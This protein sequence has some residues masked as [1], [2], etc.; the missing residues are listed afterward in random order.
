MQNFQNNSSGEFF[1]LIDQ[2]VPERPKPKVDI[3]N[4]YGGLV[5]LDLKKTN[6]GQQASGNNQRPPY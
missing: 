6:N 4:E 5:D 3:F 2:G 1:N